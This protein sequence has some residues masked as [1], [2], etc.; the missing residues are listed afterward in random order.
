VCLCRFAHEERERDTEKE[1]LHTIYKDN[2]LGVST[3][4]APGQWKSTQLSDTQWISCGQIK[5]RGYPDT[6]VPLSFDHHSISFTQRV[7][8]QNRNMITA[9]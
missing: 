4:L 2:M 6:L 8:N 9:C 1:G 3:H 7:H 5:E